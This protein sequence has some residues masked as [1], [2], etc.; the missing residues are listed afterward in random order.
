MS[1]TLDRRLLYD[2]KM[3]DQLWTLSWLNLQGNVVDKHPCEKISLWNG[4][5][6]L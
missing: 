2:V 3:K 4:V 6:A 5:N 1:V